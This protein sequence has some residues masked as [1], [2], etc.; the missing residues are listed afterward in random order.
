MV[1]N[2][3]PKLLSLKMGLMVATVLIHSI[4][5]RMSTCVYFVGCVL[6]SFTDELISLEMDLIV[7]HCFLVGSLLPSR[8]LSYLFAL[9]AHYYS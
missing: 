4:W 3:N 7:C 6:L 9:A 2:G 5:A 1:V 8:V